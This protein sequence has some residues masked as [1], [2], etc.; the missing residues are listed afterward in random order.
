MD[1]GLIVS[2]IFHN[3]NQK[4]KNSKWFHRWRFNCYKYSCIWLVWTGWKLKR[5]AIRQPAITRDKQ[6]LTNELYLNGAILND[7][8]KH[9][10]CCLLLFVAV[11]S[12]D[13][14]VVIHDGAR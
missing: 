4:Y 11:V 5:Q 12:I 6:R 13:V 3:D 7:S 1:F 14:D 2:N 8:S 9:D 10:R